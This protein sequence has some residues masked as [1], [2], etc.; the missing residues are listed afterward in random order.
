MDGRNYNKTDRI[1]FLYTKLLDGKIL[2]KDEL[3]EYFG[4]NGKSV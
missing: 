4:V 2:K 1:L 3:A